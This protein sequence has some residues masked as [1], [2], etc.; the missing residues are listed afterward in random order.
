MK[1]T[2]RKKRNVVDLRK[3]SKFISDCHI[4]FLSVFSSL[5][6]RS[7]DFQKQQVLHVFKYKGE[8]SRRNFKPCV[9]YKQAQ[10]QAPLLAEK[11]Y[12]LNPN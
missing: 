3:Y 9:S 10:K 2:R 12:N 8:I 7:A 1:A 11:T 4:I 6:S 5:L